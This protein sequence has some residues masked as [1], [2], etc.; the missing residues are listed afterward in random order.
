MSTKKFLA[1]KMI[2]EIGFEKLDSICTGFVLIAQN[3]IGINYQKW[4]TRNWKFVKIK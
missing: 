4:L 3:L 2:E 1:L